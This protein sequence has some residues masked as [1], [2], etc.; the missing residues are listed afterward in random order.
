MIFCFLY[1]CVFVKCVEEEFKIVGGIIIFDIVK[2]KLQEGEV[3]VVGG[4]V[5]KED[6]FVC[7]FDVKVGDCI[8]FG[9]WFGMEVFIGGD[10]LLIMKEFDILGIME[11]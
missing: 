10:E 8:L 11:V 1:D 7:V 5:I 9:K 6:G 2:E 3:V 4:G